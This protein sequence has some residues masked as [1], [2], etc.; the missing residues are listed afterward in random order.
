MNIKERDL[1]ICP[2][3][4]LS[5]YCFWF[6]LNPLSLSWSF[7]CFWFDFNDD[8]DSDFKSSLTII[9]LRHFHRHWYFTSNILSLQ[10]CIS[11]FLNELPLAFLFESK[12]RISLGLNWDSPP[13]GRGLGEPFP[14]S[15]LKNKATH[16][17]KLL[18][19]QERE[20]ACCSN[21]QARNHLLWST[22]TTYDSWD[23]NHKF[24]QTWFGFTKSMR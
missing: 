16:L 22:T 2:F 21:S 19:T 11:H 17:A 7:Y 6:D 18:T 24:A 15:L 20:S 8:N 23:C 5:F 3:L 9:I 4:P 13:T 14:Q 10:H 12:E 1:F